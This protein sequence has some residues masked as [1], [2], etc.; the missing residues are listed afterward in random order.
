[1][2]KH[3]ETS[4]GGIVLD[5]IDDSSDVQL[6][7][8]GDDETKSFYLDLPD[9]RQ[10]LPDYAPK[11]VTPPP[12]ENTMTEEALDMDIDPEP[13]DI[14]EA[15]LEEDAPK[16]G[17]PEPTVTEEPTVVSATSSTTNTS[18]NPLAS[19]QYFEVVLQNLSNCVN[20]ELIDSATIDFLL[21]LNTKNNRKKLA[22]SLFNVQR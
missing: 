7:P 19:K 4:S 8:W 15:P 6:D 13:M 1:M 21:N 5:T 17:T 9:L 10:F 22:R 16:P 12:E 18:Q 2:P 11:N 3:I 14:G 20:K